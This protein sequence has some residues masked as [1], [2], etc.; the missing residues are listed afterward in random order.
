VESAGYRTTIQAWDFRP[1]QNFVVAM[2]DAASSAER[3]LAVISPAFFES[4]FTRAEWTAA[5]SKDPDGSAGKLI[6]VRVRECEPP[7]LLHSTVYINLIGLGEVAARTKLLD[8][9]DAGRAMPVAQPIFPGSARGTGGGRSSRLGAPDFPGELPPIWHIPVST[10]SFQGR[11]SALAEIER[12]LGID[13]RAAVTQGR[14]IH[15]LGGIGKTQ[16]A[17]RFAV[18]H[19]SRYDVVWWVRAEHETVRLADYAALGERLALLE[20]D[21]PQSALVETTKLWLERSPRWLLIFDNV[22]DPSAIADLLPSGGTGHVIITSRRHADWRAFG[23]T[24]L[25]LDVWRREES[26]AYLTE[27]TGSSDVEHANRIAALLGDLPLALA[28]AAAY[29]NEQA[30]ALKICHERLARRSSTLLR[31]GQPPGYEHTVATTWDLAFEEIK[32]QPITASLLTLCAYMAPE[33]IPRELLLEHGRS[34]L[35]VPAND[36]GERSLDDALAALLGYA[37]VTPTEDNALDMHRLVQQIVRE[38]ASAERQDEAVTRAL[39]L[40]VAS[41][42]YEHEDPRVWPVCARLA[43]HALAVAAN[44]A[45]LDAVTDMRVSLLRAVASFFLRRGD[46]VPGRELLESTLEVE[47]RLYDDDDGK[48]ATTLTLL[49]IA[50]R[51]LG[52]IPAARVS[53]ERAI[54]IFERAY[55]GDSP[56]V[57]KALGNLGILQEDAG[58]LAAARD[59][60]LR[61]LGIFEDRFGDEHA[62]VARTLGN[63]ANV[64]R[65]L[66]DFE[67]AREVLERCMRIEDRIYE[68][69]HPERARTL[70]SFAQLSLAA[71]DRKGART[72]LERAVEVFLSAYGPEHPDTSDAQAALE[73]LDSG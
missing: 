73:W 49:G 18:E 41:F 8:G 53:I 54:A 36:D 70:G 26:V 63:L 39:E 52:E 32:R 59:T 14:A 29:A 33:R 11:E 2:Q 35:G 5:F 20:A 17:A 68:P 65:K 25:Q 66:D 46:Y 44:A 6:P 42:P 27:R 61:V 37:L 7:G 60:L 38:R 64:L 62:D 24:P 19:R 21:Q 10:P 71:G 51:R 23:I 28:Q 30:I 55:G 48:L 3:T 13:G 47:E 16:L 45:Q 15:G 43:P 31:R 40:L 12:G 58:D 57:M 56:A 69:G 9:I 67:G 1:G 4:R 34:V 50:Q 72:Y 22:S